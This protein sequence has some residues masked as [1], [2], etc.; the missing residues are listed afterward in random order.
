VTGLASQEEQ[1]LR[2]RIGD[3]SVSD[4]PDEVD[5]AELRLA[6]H[7][8][9][10]AP[11]GLEL[12]VVQRWRTLLSQS[13]VAGLKEYTDAAGHLRNLDRPLF[14]AVSPSCLET[15][16]RLDSMSTPQSLGSR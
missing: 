7:V 16:Q 13:R 8:A 6:R 14:W 12:R 5:R 4:E 10:K 11:A 9:D 2:K 3:L 15:A 1:A